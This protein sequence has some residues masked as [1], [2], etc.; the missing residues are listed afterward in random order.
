M[1]TRSVRRLSPLQAQAPHPVQGYVSGLMATSAMP[2]IS[3]CLLFVCCI[4]KSWLE[5]ET[6][7]S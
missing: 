5:G 6:V 2:F 3:H 7:S 1:A 4:S